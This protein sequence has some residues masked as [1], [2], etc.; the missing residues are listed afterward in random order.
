[1]KITERHPDSTSQAHHTPEIPPLYTPITES[2]R[3]ME[4]VSTM[5]KRHTHW[6]TIDIDD[7]QPSKLAEQ[8]LITY[9]T[10]GKTAS[11]PHPLSHGRLSP[12]RQRQP[13]GYTVPESAERKQ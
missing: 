5:D 7:I 1:M 2:A 4:G 10:E 6:E 8:Y 3:L 12:F 9:R 13:F 11:I